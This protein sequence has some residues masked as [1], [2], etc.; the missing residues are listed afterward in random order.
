MNRR[1]EVRTG[2]MEV[3]TRGMGDKQERRECGQEEWE[4]EHEGRGMVTDSGI[5]RRDDDGEGGWGDK[6]EGWG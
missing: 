1:I 6:D 4:G 2:R 5:D 3:W